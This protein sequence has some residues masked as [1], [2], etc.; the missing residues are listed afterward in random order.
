MRLHAYG[1]ASRHKPH[2]RKKMQD[3][4]RRYLSDGISVQQIANARRKVMQVHDLRD[5]TA[6]PRKS[7][8]DGLSRYRL[9]E[10]FGAYHLRMRLGPRIVWLPRVSTLTSVR[11]R[12][13]SS[14]AG[15][16][17]C[18]SLRL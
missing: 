3:R 14:L 7:E 13:L 2:A 17:S 16:D 6:T 5:S 12:L 10:M 11:I 18:V 4:D 9:S 15:S 1:V 8:S